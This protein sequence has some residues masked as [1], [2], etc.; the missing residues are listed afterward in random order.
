MGPSGAAPGM[1][2]DAV[3]AHYEA[4]ME[5]LSERESQFASLFTTGCCQNGWLTR[6]D[7]KIPQHAMHSSASCKR[8]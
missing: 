3:F 1:W 2:D 6:T 5:S 8:S 4:M 7:G